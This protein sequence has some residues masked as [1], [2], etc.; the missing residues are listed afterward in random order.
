VTGIHQL[1]AIAI[2]GSMG[3]LARFGL[4][5]AVQQ[6]ASEVFPWG[7]LVVNL[8]GCFLVGILV[9]TFDVLVIPTEWRTFLTI[10]FLAAFTTFSTYTLETLNLLREGEIGL[11]LFNIVASNLGGLVCV[12]IGIYVSRLLLK[13]II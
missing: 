10:G 5:T 4:S 6:G 12:V 1:V 7:T 3:A 8:I 11:A 2:G 9:E 13:S